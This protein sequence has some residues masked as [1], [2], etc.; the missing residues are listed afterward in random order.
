MSNTNPKKRPV[1]RNIQI[2]Q[3]MN[4]RLPLAGKLSILHRISGI[5]LFLALPVILLPLFDKSL[6][7]ELTFAE[8]KV[9]VDNP[10]LKL[11]LLGLL[12]SYMHHFC[13]GIRY[14]FLDAHVGVDKYTAA[15]TAASVF[16]VSL[17]LTA[18]FGLKLFG[19]L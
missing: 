3:I 10:L 18:I 1:Y 14:L 5:L 7:S 19:V 4:Y 6:S 11:V 12:W 17:L 8:M 2:S 16:V 9:M 13:A 15:K